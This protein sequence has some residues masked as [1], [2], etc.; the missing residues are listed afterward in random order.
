MSRTTLPARSRAGRGWARWTVRRQG[1]AP[2]GPPHGTRKW[3]RAH[4]RR[5][6]SRRGL[7]PSRSPRSR[8]VSAETRSMPFLAQLARCH[9]LEPCS[10]TRIRRVSTTCSTAG[11]SART[12]RHT[13]ASTRGCTSATPPPIAPMKFASASRAATR[14]PL[15]G[16]GL[17]LVHEASSGR[18]RDINRIAT[19]R[20]Q[21]YIAQESGSASAESLSKPPSTSTCSIER[22]AAPR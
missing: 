15:D 9:G 6:E 17:A 21:A 18:L 12:A 2:C 22:T 13:P 3:R 16:D 14:T 4:E 5:P 11:G 8:R 20:P 19:R 1:E 10:S 7:A